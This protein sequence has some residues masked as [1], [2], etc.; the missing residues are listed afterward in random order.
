MAALALSYPLMAYFGL[1]L[2][3]PALVAALLM[4]LLLVRL[5]YQKGG[6]AGGYLK[7]ASVMIVMVLG[8]SVLTNSTVGIR[9]YPV[10]VNLMLLILFVT[11][12]F[13]PPPIIERLARLREPVLAPSG[14]VYTRKVTIVWSV[15]FFLNGSI[16]LGTAM[17][18]DM[19]MWALY[20]GLIAYLF[21]GGLGAGEWLI[22][23]KVQKRHVI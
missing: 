14:V 18:A 5:K 2:G 1:Q 3:S 9:F 7:V 12:L 10:M 17:W 15:F 21:M 20:N 6:F 8:V 13:L 23:R 4:G 19:K 16:A 11:S 22:R